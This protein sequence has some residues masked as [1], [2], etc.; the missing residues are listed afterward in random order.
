MTQT[1]ERRF[2]VEQTQQGRYAYTYFSFRG[3]FSFGSLSCVYG[4]RGV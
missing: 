1:V 4:D 3:Y 2:R